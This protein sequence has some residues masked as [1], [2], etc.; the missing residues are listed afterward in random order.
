MTTVLTVFT[1]PWTGPLPQLADTVAELGL[2]GVELPVRPGYQVTPETVATGLPAAARIL[3]E[4]GLQIRSVAG[5]ID[6]ATIAACG[7]AGVPMIRIC[8][9]VDMAIGFR[10]TVEA[11]RRQFDA[12]IPALER[13][14][15]A[16]GIQ[17]HSGLQIGSAAGVLYL[18]EPYDP[19]HV[20]AVLDMAHCSV[21][22][23]P[24]A[25]AVDILADRLRLANFKSAYQRRITAP[26]EEAAYKV[27]WTTHQHAA[28]SWRDFVQALR[29]IGYS[30]AY[31]LPAEY[32]HPSGQGQRMGDEVL[33]FL[34]GDV[35]HLK[36][37][38][39]EVA[40]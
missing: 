40:G 9:A 13:Y 3:A 15:V 32:S 30:G 29:K 37:L 18:I 39:R 27:H 1:K 34:R 28:Y 20:C 33:P 6:E 2:Q 12:L 7:E 36:G 26:E 19:K 35:A 21:A 5:P 25:L 8:V 17:N 16:I 14:G 23:E 22:G 38:L 11:Y 10:A 24:T 4:R 31:C